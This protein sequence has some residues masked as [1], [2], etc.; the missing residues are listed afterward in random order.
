M[1][2]KMSRPLTIISNIVTC[3]Y[4]S[5][6]SLVGRVQGYGSNPSSDISNKKNLK[7]ISV[8]IGFKNVNS[9]EDQWIFTNNPEGPPS[10]HLRL[11]AGIILK[12][13]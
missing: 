10:N 2:R 5:R 9:L 1:Q 12:V 8:Y 11:I 3:T 7:K 13:E 4:R 6:R